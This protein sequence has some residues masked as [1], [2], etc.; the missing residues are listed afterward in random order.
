[1]RTT[2]Y[3]YVRSLAGPWLLYDNHAD[4]HQLHNLIDL[5]EHAAT[6]D[7]LDAD[8]DRHL[9]ERGDRFLPSSAYL[10]RWGY[11]VDASGTVPYSN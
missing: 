1:M 2:R 11:E 6:R 8:L 7:A 10:S 3:T 9:S 4:P 5:P